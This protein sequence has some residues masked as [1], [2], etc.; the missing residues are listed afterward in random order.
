[1]NSTPDWEYSR[2]LPSR[3]FSVKLVGGR[4]RL[5]KSMQPRRCV[6]EIFPHRLKARNVVRFALPPPPACQREDP[7][8]E[9]SLI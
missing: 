7:D 3:N 2:T 9:S 4:Q 5:T 8:I 1:M 6:T